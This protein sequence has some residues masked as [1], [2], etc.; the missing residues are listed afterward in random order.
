M[1]IGNDTTGNDTVRI[2]LYLDKQCNGTAATVTQILESDDFQ[3]FNNLSNKSRFRT[4]M[5]RVYD[6]N[7]TAGMGNGTAN[8]TVATQINDSLFK[9][10]NLPIEYDSTAGAIAEIRSNNICMLILS[11]DGRAVLDSQM[12]LRYSDL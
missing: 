7:A 5:D 9:K 4:L 10:V 3:S 12:R 1:N 2:I 8:D 11:K 6:L